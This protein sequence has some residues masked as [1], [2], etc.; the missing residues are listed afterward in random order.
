MRNDDGQSRLKA[1]ATRE[2]AQWP[3]QK[4]RN[5]RRIFLRNSYVFET[6]EEKG[7]EHVSTPQGCFPED[8]MDTGRNLFQSQALSLDGMPLSQ[9]VCIS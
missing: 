5:A 7:R 8:D 1:A 9:L 4:L 2:V 6:A 3:A